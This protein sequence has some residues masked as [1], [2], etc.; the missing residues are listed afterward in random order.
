MRVQVRN[1]VFSRFHV[2]IGIDGTVDGSSLAGGEARVPAGG[3]AP[4]Q[5]IAR[6]RV[7]IVRVARKLLG[8][9]P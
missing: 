2:E 5:G 9:D 1:T 8:S 4:V 6:L 7:A 3:P